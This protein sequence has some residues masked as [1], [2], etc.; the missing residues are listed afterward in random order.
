MKTLNDGMNK[1]AATRSKL[2][3][4][5]PRLKGSAKNVLLNLYISQIKLHNLT[6]RTHVSENQKAVLDNQI[7][8]AEIEAQ[9]IKNGMDFKELDKL[10]QLLSKKDEKEDKDSDKKF[11]SMKM[12][13]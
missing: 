4:K 9:T 8:K 5:V 11:S 13:Y 6:K 1:K 7:R 10:R 2:S 12:K 3:T